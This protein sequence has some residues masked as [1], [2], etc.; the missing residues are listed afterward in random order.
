MRALIT[1]ITG[2]VGSHLAEHLVSL[3]DEVAGISRSGQ[4][5]ADWTVGDRVKI[6]RGD[7]LDEAFLR[8]VIEH[9]RPE[10]VY[11]VAAVASV[12][13]SFEDPARTWRT[14]LD[15]TRTLYDVLRA[16]PAERRPRVVFAST[17]SIYRPGARDEKLDETAV[18]APASPYAASKAAADLLSFQVAVNYELHIIRLRCFNQ[19][20]PRQRRGFVAADVAWQIVRAERG[21]QPPEIYVGDTRAVRD[22]VDVRD[23]VRAFRLVLDCAEPGAVFNVGSGVGRTVAELIDGLVALSTVPVK[24]RHDP[25]RLRPGDPT[26]LVA[27]PKRLQAATS[28]QA[29]V[30]LERTLADILDDWRRRVTDTC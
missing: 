4:G 29:Q 3:G 10:V 12:P 6:Y 28:W 27:D 2:F 21:E 19:I 26:T 16:L 13:A 14:N 22:F 25:D 5:P 9:V 8:Q 20:G 17:G 30:P 11:H 24:V 15:G 7:L 1:G 23:V 18:L